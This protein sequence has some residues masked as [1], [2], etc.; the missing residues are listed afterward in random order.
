MVSMSLSRCGNLMILLF[1]LQAYHQWQKPPTRWQPPLVV[2][3]TLCPS[4]RLKTRVDG[5][6]CC[7]FR[8]E[9]TIKTSIKSNRYKISNKINTLY[10]IDF[11]GY[12]IRICGM[13]RIK[14]L[15]QEPFE[16]SGWRGPA[17]CSATGTGRS[18][19]R[20]AAA[21]WGTWRWGSCRGRC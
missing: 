16:V 18:R 6:P 13:K 4:S 7:F 1:K 21:S 14:R 11:I 20:G 12:F 2:R 19:G 15:P 9:N 17:G 5:K 8:Q 10:A 3:F